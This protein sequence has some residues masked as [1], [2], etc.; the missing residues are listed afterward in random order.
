VASSAVARPAVL[1]FLM[2]ALVVA[3]GALDDPG[4]EVMGQSLGLT[5]VGPWLTR[6]RV[7]LGFR[8]RLRNRIVRLV[9]SPRLARLRSLP[10]GLGVELVL[11][12]VRTVN[13]VT[14]GSAPEGRLVELDGVEATVMPALPEHALFNSA[15][16]TH[17]EALSGVL[18]ELAS[19]YSAARVEAWT[20]RV[21]AADRRARRLL[22]R[23][24]HRL[25]SSPMSMGRRLEGIERPSPSAL[26]DWTSSG[27]P[28]V[29]SALCDRVFGFGT[30]ISLAFSGLSADSAR[31]YVAHLDDEP[32]STLLT[33]D[34]D[35]NC[36]VVWVATV[37][38]ARRRGLSTALLRHA[39]ADAAERGCSTSTLVASPTGRRGYKRLGYLDP[40]PLEQWDRWTVVQEQ[41]QSQ[42]EL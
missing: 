11:D 27:D 38:E 2:S 19:I 23:A 24:G 20:V 25:V 14:C 12:G 6:L 34:H 13:R 3:S 42:H 33:C 39:L 10:A 5:G 37:P 29:L 21:P 15:I 30:A 36:A 41:D 26:S 9:H 32:V 18:D 28:R 8:T 40:G 31:V 16:C 4:V 17:S 35:G 1:V 7:R 22:K